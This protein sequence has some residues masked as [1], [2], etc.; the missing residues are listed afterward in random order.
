MA[1]KK[2]GNWWDKSNLTVREAA[3]YYH[4]GTATLRKMI[5][6][7]DCDYVFVVGNKHLIMKKEFE[8]YMRRER[9]AK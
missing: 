1:A 4:I 5:A 7:P 9:K 3:E 6:Q 8:K 2:V